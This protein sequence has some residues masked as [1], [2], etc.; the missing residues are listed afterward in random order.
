MLGH[1]LH[2]VPPM[3]TKKMLHYNKI[4]PVSQNETK[5]R[6]IVA[7]SV[8]VTQLKWDAVVN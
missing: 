5:G 8:S 4:S 3:L 1:F 7:F 2:T 6:L